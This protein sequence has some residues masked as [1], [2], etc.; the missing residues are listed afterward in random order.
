M[1]IINE[2]KLKSSDDEGDF[3]SDDEDDKC[4]ELSTENI[5]QDPSQIINPLS[6]TLNP[7][8]EDFGMKFKK[9]DYSNEAFQSGIRSVS[10]P[11]D[12]ADS[13][14][15]EEYDSEAMNERESVDSKKYKVIPISMVTQAQE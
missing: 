9:Q 14:E 4:I 12:D 2:E 7:N 8:S 1:S 6:N 3:H 11:L 15:D 10:C 5:M 13:N